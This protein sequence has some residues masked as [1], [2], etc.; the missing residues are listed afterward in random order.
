MLQFMGSGRSGSERFSF[1]PFPPTPPYVPFGIRRFGLLSRTMLFPIFLNFC[2]RLIVPISVVVTSYTFQ[3]LHLVS[4]SCR[5]I[6]S[7][8]MLQT[9]WPFA[10]T[11]SKSTTLASADFSAF[12]VTT[13]YADAETS[14][15]KTYIFHRLLAKSTHQ[16]YGHLWEL[17]CPLPTCPLD[18]P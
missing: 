9:I 5:N 11:C 12:V 16:G 17:R 6:R 15:D 3:P 18:A 1:A 10:L 14:R 2:Y 4:N 7:Q 8:L 13:A